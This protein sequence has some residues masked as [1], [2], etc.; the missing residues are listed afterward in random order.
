MD[1][2][3]RSSSSSSSV[4]GRLMRGSWAT[5]LR[6]IPDRPLIRLARPVCSSRSVWV[7]R[8]LIA[9][10]GV[11]VLPSESAASTRDAPSPLRAPGSRGEGVSL[12][13]EARTY[14]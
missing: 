4:T 12:Q 1:N 9:S 8:S 3:V 14:K 13:I 5:G 6:N 2:V 7:A 10:S 11:P